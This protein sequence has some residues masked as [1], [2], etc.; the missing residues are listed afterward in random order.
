[1][2]KISSFQVPPGS[3]SVGVRVIDTTSAITVPL[4]MVTPVIKGH[5]ILQCPSFAF[6]IEHPSGRKLLFDLGVRKDW[7]NLPPV[8][9]NHIKQDGWKLSVRQGV[10]EIL[11]EHGVAAKDIEA[12]IWSHWHYDHTGD[13]SV[14]PASAALIVGPGFKETFLPGYPERAESPILQSDV[15]GR[16]VRELDFKDA[17]STLQVGRFHAV[18]C[19]GD[20]SFFI[21]DSPGH[22]LGHICALA[23][24]TV[25]PA[26][27]IF[28]G[29]DCCHHLGEMRPS[30]YLP[31]PDS[32]FPNPLEPETAMPCPGALFE[33]LLR[34]GDRA[35]PFYGQMRP[36]MILCD[37]DV[38]DETI[39][40]AQ[41]ADGTGSVMVV[42]AHD[43][44]MLGKIDFFPKYANDFLAQGWVE[45]TRWAFLEDFKD[46]I[47][48]GS[49]TLQQHVKL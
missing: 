41:E 6:L 46:A 37:P 3:C 47:P 48:S 17:A 21:L 18:D 22:T 4:D 11:D 15:A 33:H 49:E 9:V 13:P 1:M 2:A 27:F 20:G 29:G 35:R 10:H 7:E 36:G 25:S 19:F 32:I 30:A 44:H 42:I 5:E 34:D 43:S 14:F 39:E 31:L 8:V 12:I 28:M 45:E 40:K 24:V 38:A 16:E 26:S 23:R